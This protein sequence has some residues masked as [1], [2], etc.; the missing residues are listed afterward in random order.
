VKFL[1][2]ER[3]LRLALAGP[4][5]GL[6][7]QVRFAPRPRPGWQPGFGPGDSRA[8]AV[9][10][11]LFPVDDQAHVLFTVRSSHLPSHAGQVSL[12]G[13]SVE[14]GE[15]IEMAAL[16]EAYE[17]VALD[18]ASV[19]LLGRLTPLHI[20]VSGFMLYPVVGVAD[21]RPDLR[22]SDAEVE[23]ILEAGLDELIDPTRRLLRRV[24]HEERGEVEIPYIDVRGA[25]LWGATA[26][27]LSEL[28]W[29]IDPERPAT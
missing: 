12:P 16:R 5:P 6:E 3:R 8:A 28:L 19:R 29:L 23:R 15:T 18:P 25:Q 9:L 4:L 26:M 10:L 14:A 21:G 1:D 2:V 22:P 7:A 13:G 24:L 20:P 17:E 11:L 27:V